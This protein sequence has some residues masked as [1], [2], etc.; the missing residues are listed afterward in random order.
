MM[1]SKVTGAQRWVV[2]IG[3]ALLTAD[4]KGLDRKAMGV[5]VEQMVALHEAGVELVLVSSGAVAAGMSR[6][7]WTARPSAMHELQAAAA[8][9]QMGLVQAW[10][11]SFAEHGR[12]T[13][14]ILLTHD[15]L[16]DRKRYLNARSTLRAL[17]ELKVIPVINENDT[18]VTDEIRF[19]DNDTL[20]AL[21]ANL[22]EADLLV[23]ATDVNAAFIDF[24]KPTQKAIGQAH[25]DEM[26]KLGFAAGS[27]GPKVQAACEFARHTGKVAVIGSL[28]DIEAI[29]QGKAGT[30]ISTAKPGISYL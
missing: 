16:S 24:G 5:W 19:G 20:A 28:S 9:G 22:V 4:G 23:I 17:V 2:K 10:E 27:M 25:P 30:R 21:V 14:Q 18:V 12:H 3:S 6:L 1:R 11:S 7:G 15:D 26:E 8:I 29:V 13:A